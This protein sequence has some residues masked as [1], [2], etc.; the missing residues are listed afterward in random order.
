[1]RAISLEPP[2]PRDSEILCHGSL[3]GILNPHEHAERQEAIE[4]Q[5]ATDHYDL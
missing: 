3:H 2:A 4:N 1:M 5:E